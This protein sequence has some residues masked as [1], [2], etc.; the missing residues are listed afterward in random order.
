VRFWKFSTLVLN[1]LLGVG[2]DFGLDRLLLMFEERFGRRPTT[3]LVALL[4]AAVAAWSLHTLWSD[5]IAPIYA[6][7]VSATTRGQTKI[8]LTVQNFIDVTMTI[9]VIAVLLAIIVIL[10]H[11]LL[12]WAYR[13]S[14]KMRKKTPD[15]S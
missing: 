14:A 3:A 8:P 15:G 10:C 12:T 13:D 5:L 9:F 2:V 4:A 11:G 1:A 7:T 6:W